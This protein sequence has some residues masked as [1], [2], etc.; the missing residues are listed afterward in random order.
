MTLGR[1]INFENLKSLTNSNLG[2]S[3][4]VKKF[5]FCR[6]G[7]TEGVVSR[8]SNNHELLEFGNFRKMDKYENSTLIETIQNNFCL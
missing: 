7:E 1:G 3:L 6:S 2:A 4:L 8:K 5:C